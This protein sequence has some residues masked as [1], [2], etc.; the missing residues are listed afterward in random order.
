MKA[1]KIELKITILLTLSTH[2]EIINV[3]LNDEDFIVKHIDVIVDILAF[4]LLKIDLLRKSFLMSFG[5]T[6]L[7]I[8]QFNLK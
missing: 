2:L 6:N 7:L 4:F 1:W 3:C 5:H 8:F